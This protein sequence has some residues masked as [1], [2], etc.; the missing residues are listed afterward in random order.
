MAGSF[1]D[2]AAYERLMGRWSRRVADPFLSWLDPAPGGE[3]ID[4]GCGNG[5]FSE[6]ILARC[7]PR[8]L[9]GIDPAPDQ[10]AFARSRLANHPAAE[11]ALGDAQAL[12]SADDSFDVAGMALVL[13]FLPDPQRAVREMARVVRP[14]GLVASYM[15]DVPGRGLPLWPVYAACAS[16][17]HG[18]PLPPSSA[19]STAE[20]MHRLW[21]EA[22]LQSVESRRI[23]I[24]VSFA[25]FDDFWDSN[26][27][28]IGPQGALL[29]SL[30]P[31]QIDAVKAVLRDM[32]PP[33]A[34]GSIR[35][36]AAASAVKGRVAG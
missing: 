4:I 26:S 19:L 13:V 23:E 25:D 28:P 5:A 27:I 18:S 12:D 10:I 8:R 14:S 2:G 11:F 20:A 9:L 22:G 35:Y 29:A 32:L 6:E 33:E 7:A 1:S 21:V 31:S 3:W 30:S 24:T 16:L 34:D 17:G 15:W 36:Q